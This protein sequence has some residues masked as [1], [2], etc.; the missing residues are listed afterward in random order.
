M[1]KIIGVLLV[2][3]VFAAGA[4][5]YEASPV[6]AEDEKRHLSLEEAVEIARDENPEVNLAEIGVEKAKIN[7]RDTTRQAEDLEDAREAGARFS[8]PGTP[9]IPEDLYELLEQPPPEPTPGLG[10]SSMEYYLATE[11]APRQ[12]EMDLTMAEKGL[13]ATKR[14]VEISVENAYYEVLRAETELENAES[15]L[16]RAEEELRLAE[17]NYEVGTAAGLEVI[18]AEVNLASKQAQYTAAKN[19][20]ESAV[21]DFNNTVGLPLEEEINLT[22]SFEFEPAEVNLE[23][24]VDTAKEVDLSYIGAQEGEVIA[25]KQ[26]DVV[27]RHYTPTVYAYREAQYE[28]EEAKIEADQAERDLIVNVNDAYRSLES[29]EERYY[30]VKEALEQAEESYRLTKLRYEVG[31]GT[32]MELRS[33]GGSLDDARAELLSAMYDY[34][35]MK[36]QLEH[37][38]YG[39]GE[40]AGGVGGTGGAAA[41]GMNGGEPDGR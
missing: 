4:Y 30:T 23:E 7:L 38:V 10:M 28:Y 2:A 13:E 31:M 21:M 11:V 41:G 29:A 9:A 32:H 14:G 3:A 35:I 33:A 1:K 25:E 24:A 20:Y 34:N 16:D 37:G 26:Y 17:V 36:A 39:A 15:A 5:Y 18:S 22:S 12:A 6:T 19:D 27:D 8:H 40:G